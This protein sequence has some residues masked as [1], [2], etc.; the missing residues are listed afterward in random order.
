MKTVTAEAMDV[1]CLS[2]FCFEVNGMNV[3]SVSSRM[4]IR[5]Y[6]DFGFVLV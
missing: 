2:L 5:V 4:R 3:N 6:I 1:Y